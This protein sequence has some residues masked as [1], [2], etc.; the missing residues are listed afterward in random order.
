M[1][2]PRSR[3]PVKNVNQFFCTTCDTKELSPPEFK[4]HLQEVHKIT[5]FR[6]ARTLQLHLDATDHWSSTYTWKIHGIDATQCIVQRRTRAQM[7]EWG[8]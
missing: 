5:D 4:V 2:A 8:G 3:I 1:K 6:G 7:K